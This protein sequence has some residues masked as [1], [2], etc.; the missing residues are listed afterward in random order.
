[1][2][3]QMVDEIMYQIAA[4]LPPGYRGYYSDL[5]AATERYLEFPPGSRSN[6]IR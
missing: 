1:M 6:L 4:L 5:A 3:Q 2:R